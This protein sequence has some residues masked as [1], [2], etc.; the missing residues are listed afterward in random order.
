MKSKGSRVCV[1]PVLCASNR[2]LYLSWHL[3]IERVY[4]MVGDVVDLN[5]FEFFYWISPLGNHETCVCPGENDAWLGSVPGTP[6]YEFGRVG[7]FVRRARGGFL[8]RGGLCDGRGGEFGRG[9]LCDGRGG[10]Y[11][12]GRG[13]LCDLSNEFSHDGLCKLEVARVRYDLAPFGF[14]EKNVAWFFVAKGTGN[15]VEVNGLTLVVKD[16]VDVDWW[17]SD[18]DADAYKSMS[19]RGVSAVLFGRSVLQYGWFQYFLHERA[20][21]AVRLEVADTSCAPECLKY[22][23]GFG[24]HTQC[25]PDRSARFLNCTSLQNIESRSLVPRNMYVP[26]CVHFLR[27]LGVSARARPLPVI[28]LI[29]ICLLYLKVRVRMHEPSRP[30]CARTR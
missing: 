30:S 20:E 3:Y 15:Y 14:G 6:E 24:G 2:D 5:E 17:I 11:E 7:F 21:M 4:G 13:G 9:G 18:L 29:V 8:C 16:R 19:S 12:F 27:C 10:T 23:K 22:Y 28:A 26:L 25:F 1:L